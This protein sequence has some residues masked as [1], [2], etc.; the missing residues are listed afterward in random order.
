MPRNHIGHGGIDHVAS[1]VSSATT[2][3]TSPD[4]RAAMYS[5]T[6]SATFSSPSPRSVSC[7]LC[8]GIRSS[9]AL[10]A[11][12]SALLTDAT[13]VSSVSATSAAEKPRT[14][15]MISTARCVAGRCWRAATNA[16]SSASRCS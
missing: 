16:S 10:R 3:S 14:S 13:D 5:S 12:C 4:S 11:R 9:A 1:S 15:R 7:W 8:S 2:R 6:I